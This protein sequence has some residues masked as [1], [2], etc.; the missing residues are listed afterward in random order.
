MPPGPNSG[1][2]KRKIYATR[3][4]IYNYHCRRPGPMPVQAAP[5]APK[6]YL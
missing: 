6:R 3:A 5:R 1:Y 2:W 4:G